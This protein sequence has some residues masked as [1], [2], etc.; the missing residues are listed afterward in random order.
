[1]LLLLPRPAEHPACGGNTAAA[2]LLQVPTSA[3]LRSFFIP[4]RAGNYTFFFGSDDQ[5]V[6][7]ATYFD[8]SRR[9]QDWPGT[10]SSCCWHPPQRRG[11]AAPP[12]AT[13]RQAGRQRRRQW[14]ETQQR[15]Q[16]GNAPCPCPTLR[17]QA[18][19]GGMVTRQLA[20]VTTWSYPDNFDQFASQRSWP[21]P[22]Q[23]GQAL[24][25]EAFTANTGST[26]V[27]T[28]GVTVPNPVAK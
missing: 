2:V 17:L 21:L 28:V 19:T 18:A 4:P 26:G 16:F 20:S 10:M 27:L 8:V 13:C 3:R 14:S 25:L 7:N 15:T 1:M 22:L 5:G 12:L 24:L 9:P 6:L 11:A 23:P